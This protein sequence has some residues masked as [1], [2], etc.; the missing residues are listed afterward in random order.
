MF[1]TYQGSQQDRLWQRNIDKR[2]AALTNY[3]TSTLSPALP[4]ISSTYFHRNC[5]NTKKRHMA[6][7]TEEAG[8]RSE[9]ILYTAVCGKIFSLKN[10]PKK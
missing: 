3:F 6:K 5:I 9:A 4:T 2:E 1:P 10:G 7:V 8:Y